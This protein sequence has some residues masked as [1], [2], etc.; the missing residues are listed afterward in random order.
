MKTVQITFSIS[1]ELELKNLVIGFDDTG[2]D[3]RT[4]IKGL[5]QAMIKG[6][7]KDMWINKTPTP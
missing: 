5:A 4:L 7:E 1:D 2:L 6:I 3:D